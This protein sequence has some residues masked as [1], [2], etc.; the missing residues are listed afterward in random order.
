MS[1]L[2]VDFGNK[3]TEKPAAT[4]DYMIAG[5]AGTPVGMRQADTKSA[6]IRN[7]LAVMLFMLQFF[8]LWITVSPY[9]SESVALSIEV[10]PNPFNQIVALLLL[11]GAVCFF[12]YSPRRSLALQPRLLTGLLLGWIFLTSVLSPQ[13]F[14][15]FKQFVLSAILIINASVMLLLP[16]SE[17]QFAKLMIIGMLIMLGFAYFGIVFLPMQ[18]IHQ[19]STQLGDD[20]LG[21]WRGHFPHK[22]VAS[23]A[24]VLSGFYALY[25]MGKGY[26]LAGWVILILSVFFLMHT[27][28]KTS[29]AMF[30]LIL[31]VAFIFE[32]LRWTRWLIVIG[33]VVAINFLTVGAA[34]IPPVYDFVE[35]LGIDPTFTNRADI[36]RFAVRAIEERPFLGH[37][38]HGYWL[39]ET[40]VNND[41]VE[42]WSPT[43]FNGHNA[44]VDV[45]I[46][47]GLF[48]FILLFFWV[49]L[50][51]LFYIGRISR[52]KLYSPLVRLYVRIWLYGLFGSALE[53]AFFETGSQL[54][55]SIMM[56]IFGMR[57][58]AVAVPLTDKAPVADSRE[59]RRAGRFDAHGARAE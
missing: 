57:L 46:N 21:N 20:L 12:I 52:K 29:T 7:V 45:L 9:A 49:L 30:P 44:W 24:M 25:A 34:L 43:A 5:K 16:R 6:D 3:T 41:T 55:L 35:S 56:A 54:W 26:R 22:N 10:A 47:L 15:A 39:S 42:N 19:F 11:G 8:Y 27:G 14:V 38:L 1:M 33:G 32:K 37:G 53:S 13:P 18:A 58:Q 48:G 40:L 28:G 17:E 51:P 50:L 2:Q 59:S 31:L 36:W 23:A 4:P